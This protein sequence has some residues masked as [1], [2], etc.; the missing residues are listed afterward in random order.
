[1]IK[2]I[3]LAS[4][5]GV[6]LVVGACGVLPGDTVTEPLG[7]DP[8]SISGRLGGAFRDGME[9]AWI[10]DANG[11]R[12]HLLWTEEGALLADPLRL[13]DSTG[14]V[15]ARTGDIVTVTGPSEGIALT[16]CANGE[17]TFK[18]DVITGPG[19]I[20]HFQAVPHV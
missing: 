3:S 14:S 9:C 20:L 19:G 6:A 16:T 5:L 17:S 18:V 15:I 7:G 13:V 1:M 11:K 10:D 2:L 4:V 8:V 12:T